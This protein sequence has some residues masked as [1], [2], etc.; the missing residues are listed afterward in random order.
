MSGLFRADSAV[1]YVKLLDLSTL[2][3]GL[4]N[5]CILDVAGN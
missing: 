5:E 4:S 3:A 1:I 2:P